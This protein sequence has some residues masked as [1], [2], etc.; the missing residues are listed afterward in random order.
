MCNKIK[1]INLEWYEDKSLCVVLCSI[2]YPDEYKN[3]EIKN[4]DKIHLENNEYISCRHK[5]IKQQNSIEWRTSF[6]YCH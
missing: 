4:L 6:K 3:I 2:G 1:S 5:K